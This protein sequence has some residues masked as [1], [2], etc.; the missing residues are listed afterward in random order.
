MIDKRW[1]RHAQE[2]VIVVDAS[3]LMRCVYKAAAVA[4][5]GELRMMLADEMSVCIEDCWLVRGAKRTHSCNIS[6]QR[7]RGPIKQY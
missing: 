5:A 7:L 6:K 3:I 2:E 4:A 1:Q